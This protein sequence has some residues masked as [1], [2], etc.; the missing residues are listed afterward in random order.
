VT[1]NRFP[2]P[3]DV[4]QIIKPMPAD[5]DLVFSSGGVP[6]GMYDARV[7]A[8]T[9]KD[10]QWQG[11]DLHLLEWA[12]QV[13]T[14]EGIEEVTGSTSTKTG[15]SAKMPAWT[16]ALIGRAPQAGE[17]IPRSALIGRSCTVVVVTSDKGYAKVDAVV[18]A[19]TQPDRPVL[20]EFPF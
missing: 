17:R 10:V 3:S 7:T 8:I 15:P 2:A 13:E 12:F 19:R 1:D 4:R 6:P 20:D 16:T 11:E 9:S 14:P 18:P 5:D